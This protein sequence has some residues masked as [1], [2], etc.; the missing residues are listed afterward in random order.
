[1]DRL[2]GHLSSE[3]SSAEARLLLNEF[4]HRLN[5]ELASAISVISLAA[6]RSTHDE[7]K[8][9][10]TAVQRRLQ[11]YADVHHALQMPEH[12]TCIDAAA[13][14][15]QLCRAISRSKLESSGIE[16]VL[17]EQRFQMSSERCW[18]LGLIISEL[19]TNAARHAFRAS[20]GVIRVELLPSRT[21]VECRVGDNGAAATNI[22]PG[23]GLRIIEALVEGLDG[24]IEQRFSPDGTTSILTFP[25]DVGAV[26]LP[27]E[28]RPQRRAKPIAG[29]AVKQI[30]GVAKRSVPPQQSAVASSFTPLDAHHC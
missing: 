29:P 6:A 28:L 18:R 22:T 2:T 24:R 5:N 10:L 9:A 19:V 27:E 8:V 7:V 23:R 12:S 25:L 16:L 26:E 4:G 17:V 1:M 13:Y 11:S 14:L 21:V 30:G 20:G 3:R 15:R